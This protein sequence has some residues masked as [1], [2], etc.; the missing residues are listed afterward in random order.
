MYVYE[1]CF[2]HVSSN[3]LMKNYYMILTSKSFDFKIMLPEEINLIKYL[4]KYFERCKLVK[5]KTDF[6]DNFKKYKRKRFRRTAS[7]LNQN[8]ASRTRYESKKPCYIRLNIYI[9]NVI[10]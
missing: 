1:T 6:R 9:I 8:M 5:K 2:A 4:G 7:C 10:M 3:L